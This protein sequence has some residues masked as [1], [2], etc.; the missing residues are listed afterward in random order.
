MES[1]TIVRRKSASDRTWWLCVCSCVACVREM[2]II[3]L[4]VVVQGVDIVKVV[5]SSQ[6]IMQE[7]W[8]V[9]LQL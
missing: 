2:L 6:Q 1:E 3:G 7:D 5:S 8:Q 4:V 9:Q